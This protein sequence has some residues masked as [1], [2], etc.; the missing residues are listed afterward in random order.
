MAVL[1]FKLDP[2]E[3]PS[4]PATVVRVSF[5]KSAPG[6]FE[7]SPGSAPVSFVSDPPLSKIEVFEDHIDMMNGSQSIGI[8]ASVQVTATSGNQVQFDVRAMQLN[9]TDRVGIET[10][11]IG[12]QMVQTGSVTIPF[13]V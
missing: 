8:Q 4:G 9:P 10:L 12:G 1:T 7:V 3:S 6:R 5:D 11:W 13:D 2:T